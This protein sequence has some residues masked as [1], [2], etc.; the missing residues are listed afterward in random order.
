MQIYIIT[1]NSKNDK[2][3]R[4]AGHWIGNHKLPKLI[5]FEQGSEIVTVDIASTAND[6]PKPKAGC[7]LYLISHGDSQGIVGGDCKLYKDPN[8]FLGSHQGLKAVYEQAS[9]VVLVSCSTASEAGLILNSGGKMGF[10]AA[11]F[12]TNLKNVDKKKTVVAAVG[13]VIMNNESN[14]Q[15]GMR[16]KSPGGIE[17]VVNANTEG[18]TQI[19]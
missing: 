19:S 13:P 14:E 16:V 5:A 9:K 1:F 8:A 10:Q 7:A 15:E 2:V 4:T 3:V 18:W 6:W 17:G 11:T 12:A